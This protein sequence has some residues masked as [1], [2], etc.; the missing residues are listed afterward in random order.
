MLSP[1]WLAVMVAVP[2]P[3]MVTVEP[4]IVATAVSELLKVTGL[5]D[6]PPV[7]LRVNVPSPY[8]L[9]CNG[10]KT[11]FWLERPTARVPFV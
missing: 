10:L 6:A 9:L 5:P 3:T 2:A 7:A 1:S 11:I 8:I 4:L